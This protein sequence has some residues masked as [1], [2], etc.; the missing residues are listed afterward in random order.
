MKEE[1]TT[2][3]HSEF[4]V[5]L[6]TAKKHDAFAVFQLV[7]DKITLTEALKYLRMSVEDVRPFVADWNRLSAKQIILE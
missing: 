7:S 4:T 2:K 6:G 1:L 3:M 5:T